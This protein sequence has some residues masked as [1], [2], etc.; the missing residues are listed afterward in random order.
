MIRTEAATIS[1]ARKATLTDLAII[2]RVGLQL[3]PGQEYDDWLE[4]GEKLMLADQAV[5]WAIGDWWAYGIHSYG[6]RAAAAI[7]PK[8]GENRLQRFMNYAWV[9]RSID[10]SRRK[11]VL[12]WSSHEAV[13]ALDPDIQDSILDRAIQNGWGSREIR[14]AAKEYKARIAGGNKPKLSAQT[15]DEDAEIADPDAAVMDKT[16]TGAAL[17]AEDRSQE[18][19]EVLAGLRE[20]SLSS[21][22]Q[23]LLAIMAEI[24]SMR[25]DAGF[26]AQIEP[27]GINA[28]MLAIEGQWLINT[29]TQI[30][31]RQ[32]IKSSVESP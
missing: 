32:S 14:A 17:S 16:A 21:A 8:S 2:T 5:Q 11:E 27:A 7:D 20:Q 4:I 1:P 10:T 25:S 30:K 22:N 15:P 18:R 24:K 9:A 29:A 3:Q 19:S 31:H 23:R 28:A 12:S 26:L 6:E 13:A